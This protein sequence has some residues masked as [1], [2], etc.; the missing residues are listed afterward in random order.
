MFQFRYDSYRH[1]ATPEFF[2][3]LT[4]GMA[5]PTTDI[6]RSLII[7]HERSHYF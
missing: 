1:Y 6:A 3:C 7:I 4:S 5:T 2:L